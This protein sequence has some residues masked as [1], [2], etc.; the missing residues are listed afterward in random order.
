MTTATTG[1]CK[2]FFI[3]RITGSFQ[4]SYSVFKF[5]SLAMGDYLQQWFPNFF[6]SRTICGSR[7]VN[8]YHLVPGKANVPNIIRS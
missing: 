5:P 3:F 1:A 7:T 2:T 6:W 4:R 8:T